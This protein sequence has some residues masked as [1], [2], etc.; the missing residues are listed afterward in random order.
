MSG[1]E[2]RDANFE[3]LHAIVGVVTQDAHLIHDSFRANLLY[4]KPDA[5]DG[6][7]R[8]ALAA[9]QILTFVD[10]LPEGLDTIVGDRGYR[11]SGGEKQRI[12][13]ARL[14]LKAPDV[15]V[16]DEAT[17]HLDSESEAAVQQALKTALA[18]RTSLVIAHRLSTVRDADQILVIDEG[19]IVERGR[20]ETL[21]E[22]G[23]LYA[24]LY[25]TQFRP[26]Q[27][28]AA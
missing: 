27:L 23:G 12:A 16:L 8:D 2:V 9:A 18:G 1:V 25:R 24:E 19:R 4:A 20:H 26:R 11:L 13:I 17:A 14:L 3:S 10:T 6:Q 21:V 28:V 5:T 7:L 22:A 15:V